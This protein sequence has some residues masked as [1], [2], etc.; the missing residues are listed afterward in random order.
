MNKESDSTL[1][2]LSDSTSNANDQI[3]FYESHCSYNNNDNSIERSDLITYRE[4]LANVDDFYQKLKERMTISSVVIPNGK[5]TVSVVAMKLKKTTEGYLQ[6]VWTLKII[7]KLEELVIEHKNNIVVTYKPLKR[8]IKDL[9][10]FGVSINNITELNDPK[11][12]KQFIGRKLE[13]K[14]KQKI[15]SYS[16]NFLKIL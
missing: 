12:Y 15:V 3:I 7:G 11:F 14:T 10:I 4:E 5:Y 6:L 16:T 13:I 1:L 9:A 8:L 2:N